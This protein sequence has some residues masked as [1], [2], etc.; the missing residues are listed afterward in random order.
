[1]R[2]KYHKDKKL[3]YSNGTNTSTKSSSDDMTT[4]KSISGSSKVSSHKKRK[5]RDSRDYLKGEFNK[6]ELPIFDGEVNPREE[7]E[8]WLLGM[9][10]YFQVY[11][12][13]SNMK[14]KVEIYNLNGKSFIWWKNL[15]LLNQ[16]TEKNIK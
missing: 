13:S 2:K 6:I 1:M 15:K 11:D 5:K 3:S 7:V 12:Y 4:K 9:S 14:A 16:V 10:K 8:A